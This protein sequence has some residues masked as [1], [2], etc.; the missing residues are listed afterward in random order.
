[1]KPMLNSLYKA[2]VITFP[3]ISSPSPSEKSKKPKREEG[4]LTEMNFGKQIMVTE[5]NE[6]DSKTKIRKTGLW[7]TTMLR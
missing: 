5:F 4:M 2:R 3:S 1:V 7:R 6:E